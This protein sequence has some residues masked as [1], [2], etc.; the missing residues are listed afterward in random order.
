MPV[1]AGAD[2]RALSPVLG[3]DLE[4]AQSDEHVGL[5]T[6]ERLPRLTGRRLHALGDELEEALDDRATVFHRQLEPTAEEPV[7]RLPF[8][9]RPPVASRLR[10]LTP[11]LRPL[12]ARHLLEIQ[13]RGV[14]RR[15]RDLLVGVRIREFC[16]GRQLL[17]AELTVQ[18]GITQ[19]RQLFQ[20]AGD[21]TPT[22]AFVSVIPSS[23][24][25]SFANAS[26]SSSTRSIA[27]ARAS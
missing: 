13:R 2:R 26:R 20:L 1:D 27:N 4:L 15:S 17:R 5:A 12:A 21:V 25:W 6:I 10:V 19:M 3:I 14:L 9:Q 11:R 23:A 16:G 18:H 24:A 22:L 8:P 7:G